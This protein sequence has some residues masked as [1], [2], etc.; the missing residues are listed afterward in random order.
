M[1]TEIVKIGANDV[2]ILR[3]LA[4]RTFSETFSEEY[5]DEEFAEYF[6]TSLSEATLQQELTDSE[7]QHFFAV[8]DGKPVGFLKVNVG[9]AQTEQEL[10]NGFEVQR[11]YVLADYQGL[12]L[13]KLLFEKA[14][15][16]ATQTDCD[17]VWL[18]VWEY[19]YKAQKFYAKFGFEKFGEHTFVVGDS[20][21][22][23]WLL[24]RSVASIREELNK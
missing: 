4:V 8:V 12:G 2:K 16:L 3:E 17:Y 18:G 23:D 6:N 22:T 21:D 20:N 1:S 15:Q 11:I 19:N 5:T 7:S 24:R 9:R 10:P 13:G 14:L